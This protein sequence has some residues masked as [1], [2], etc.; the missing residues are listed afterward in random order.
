L[1]EYDK[2]EDGVP[3][4]QVMG[5]MHEAKEWGWKKVMQKGERL[6]VKQAGASGVPHAKTLVPFWNQTW[7]W[8]IPIKNGGLKCFNAETIYI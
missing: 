1:P 5:A 3:L 7:Q 6:L 8:E 4:L 2:S